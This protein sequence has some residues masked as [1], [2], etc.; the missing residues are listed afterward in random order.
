V[1]FPFVDDSDRAH[2]VAAMILPFIRRMI[3]GPTPM[4]LIEAP[5]MGSGKGLLA[6]LI[7]IAATG[8]ACEARTL[9]ESEDEI[10]KMLTAE[11]MKGRPIIL[12]DNA[13]DRKQLH[14]SSLASVLTS[15]RW[16][17]R[18][19][20]ES[21]MA[22]VPNH[23]VWLMTATT[24]TCISNLRA[25]ASG[26]GSIREWIARGSA[27]SSSIPRSQPG[28]KRIGRRWWGPSSP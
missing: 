2:A 12:L 7:S 14:S 8:A 4:H 24:P 25:A 15:V 11:L 20:G 6:N 10:R 19:L 18:K 16:T 5:T 3:D 9:P 27:P 21:I 28:P 13:N 26:R 22:S 23:A 17:D 1:D